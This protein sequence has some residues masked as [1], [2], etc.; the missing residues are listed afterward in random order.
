MSNAPDSTGEN[1]SKS[2]PKQK[3]QKKKKKSTDKPAAAA[4]IYALA[5]VLLLLPVYEWLTN[6][7]YFYVATSEYLVFFLHLPARLFALVGFVL[8]FYQFVLGMR[9]PIIEKVFNRATNLKRHRTLGKIAF[10]LILLHGV[11]LLAFDYFGTFGELM[12]DTYRVIGMIAIVLMIL[13]VIPAWYFRPLK[14]SRKTWTTIHLGGYVVFPL[15]FL[16]GRALGA[17]FST[18]T[19]T[20]NVLFSALFA[21]Y[22]LLLAYRLYL[23]YTS[24]GQPQAKTAR[25]AAAK[26]KG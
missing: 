2:P 13:A 16:H 8:M 6:A 19:W 25:P 18:G 9:L 7:W 12:F 1:T 22:C 23:A 15:G 11:L 20:V 17:E 24:M 4:A 14:L 5:V 21:I 3:Q 26:A 10:V